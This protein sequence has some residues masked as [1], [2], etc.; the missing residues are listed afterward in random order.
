MAFVTGPN[1]AA[2]AAHLVGLLLSLVAPF[3]SNLIVVVALIANF[4]ALDLISVHYK[5]LK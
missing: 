4:L 2:I 1:N 3:F 5:V